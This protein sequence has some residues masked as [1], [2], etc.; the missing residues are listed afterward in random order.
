MLSPL[1]HLG[2]PSPSHYSIERSNLFEQLCGL[3]SKAAFPTREGPLSA[4]HLQSLDGILAILSSLSAGCSGVSDLGAC[5]TS[6]VMCCCAVAGQP[7]WG[8]LRAPLLREG[9]LAAAQLRRLTCRSWHDAK[10][11]QPLNCTC[12][13]LLV[14]C[15][16]RQPRNSGR[17]L[18][19]LYTA[20]CTAAS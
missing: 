10:L 14:T 6:F 8:G 18:C 17:L 3:L 5:S 13:R 16:C 9:R 19:C 7:S 15:T 12:G 11:A 2:C 1:H 4:A 20:V